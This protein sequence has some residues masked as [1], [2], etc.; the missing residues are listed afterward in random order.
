MPGLGAL[1]RRTDRLAPGMAKVPLCQLLQQRLPAWQWQPK[2][3]F[4]LPFARWPHAAQ[5]MRHHLQQ[6]TSALRD[7]G[8]VNLVPD[9]IGTMDNAQLFTLTTLSLWQQEYKV[10]L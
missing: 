3:H 2:Q 7:L 4:R 1:A 8:L 5:E 10:A 6:H 9:Q